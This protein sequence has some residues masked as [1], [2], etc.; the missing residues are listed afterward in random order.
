MGT[1]K[2]MLIVHEGSGFRLDMAENTFDLL[3]RTVSIS[4][5]GH[6]WASDNHLAALRA[7]QRQVEGTVAA[8]LEDR[9]NGQGV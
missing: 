1:P 6:K 5:L 8:V 4:P 3:M 9:K 2:V 7:L